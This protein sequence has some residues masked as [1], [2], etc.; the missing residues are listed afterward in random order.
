[1]I[2]KRVKDWQITDKKVDRTMTIKNLSAF[3]KTSRLPL[4]KM[5]YIA[6]QNHKGGKSRLLDGRWGCA[7]SFKGKPELSNAKQ[8]RLF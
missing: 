4:R 3:C 7:K 5:Y 6:R 2:D 8:M 1:M